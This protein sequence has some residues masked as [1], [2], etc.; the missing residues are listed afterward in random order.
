MVVAEGDISQ[1]SPKINFGFSFKATTA[2]REIAAAGNNPVSLFKPTACH[3]RQST[4][5]P[6]LLTNHHQLPLLNPSY[7]RSHRKLKTKLN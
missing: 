2:R 5:R 6:I 7:K 4:R 1:P 3:P